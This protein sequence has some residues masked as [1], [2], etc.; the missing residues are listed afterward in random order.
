MLKGSEESS[1]VKVSNTDNYRPKNNNT[2]V[3]IDLTW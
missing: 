1:P 3:R 2:E